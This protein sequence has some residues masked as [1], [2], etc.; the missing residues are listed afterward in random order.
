M[1]AKP[2]L[3]RKA[4]ESNVYIAD[5]KTLL[6]A[7]KI[8]ALTWRQMDQAKNHERVYELANE[9]V[10]RVQA[11]LISFMDIQSGLKSAN[12]AYESALKKLQD[13]GQSIP[14]T[15]KKL[16]KLGASS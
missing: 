9:M 16:I 1:D 8:I 6:A 3:W 5:E 15:C 11:F 14:G 10:D 12:D 2:A 4:M 13:T 7:I